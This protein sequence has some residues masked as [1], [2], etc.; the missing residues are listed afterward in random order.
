MEKP[1]KTTMLEYCKVIM[2][3]MSFDRRL[4]KKEYRKTFNYLS[5]TE[6]QRLK[7]WLREA[8]VRS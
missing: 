5:L 2:K 1:A 7:Q 3:K 4:F 8:V 6:Q